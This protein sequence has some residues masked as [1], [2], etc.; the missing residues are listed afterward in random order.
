MTTAANSQTSPGPALIATGVTKHFG[1]RKRFAA[2][3]DVS[4]SCE[5][6]QLTGIVGES[7]SGKSTL[8]RILVG[9]ER[10]SSGSMSYGDTEVQKLLAS[11]TSRL[12]F[13]RDVQFIGQDTTSSFDPRQTLRESVLKP[14]VA[15]R[16]DT[17]AAARHKASEVFDELGLPDALADR[18]PDQVSGGQRQRFSIARGLVVR[19]RFLLCDEVVSALDVSVQGKILNVIKRYCR[20]TGAGLVFVSHGLP[21]TAFVADRIVVMHRGT[22]VESGATDDILRRPTHPYTR[23]LLDSYRS[24]GAATHADAG[25]ATPAG[26]PSPDRTTSLETTP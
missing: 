11:N 10:A 22:I 7:G 12:A 21:A 13:R 9:L 6:S 17:P 16:G 26:A 5:P 4:V 24:L 14:L 18:Y 19:P 25:P 23:S 15:L 20:D 2:L 3:D 8:A 1:S